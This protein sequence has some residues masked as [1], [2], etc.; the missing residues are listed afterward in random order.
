MTR[1]FK[2]GFNGF[3]L[4]LIT[5]ICSLKLNTEYSFTLYPTT[6]KYHKNTSCRAD[7]APAP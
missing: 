4:K 7:P 3:I 1:I 6:L 5:E 2:R